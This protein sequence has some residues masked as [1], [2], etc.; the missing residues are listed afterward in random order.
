[1]KFPENAIIVLDIAGN[2]ARLAVTSDGAPADLNS[3][4]FLQEKEQFVRPIADDGDRRQLVHA[5]V[6][7]GALFSVGPGWAP[8]ELLEYYEK[9]GERFEPY[10]LISWSG[11]DLFS[12]RSH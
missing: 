4:G 11:P 8:S 2:K 3:L 7:L 6:R 5:L 1:M 10:S 9:Q 12:I